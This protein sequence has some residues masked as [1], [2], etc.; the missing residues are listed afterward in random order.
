MP[1]AIDIPGAVYRHA[2][3]ALLARVVDIE[4]TP[5]VPADVSS[6]SYTVFQIDPCLPNELVPVDGHTNVALTP[7][8]VLSSELELSELWSVDDIGHNFSH[9]I[10]VSTDEAFATAGVDYQVR[11][12]L[13]PV[14]GQKIVFRYRLRA[15]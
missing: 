8:D 9:V 4:G 3:A 1:R 10:D 6:L 15:L 14:V 12:E 5:L 13:V 7:G 11:Y 2:T